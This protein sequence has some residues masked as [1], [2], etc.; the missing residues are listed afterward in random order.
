M[1]WE[2]L[3]QLPGAA[4]TLGLEN[5]GQGGTSTSTCPETEGAA[6]RSLYT[7]WRPLSPARFV[8]DLHSFAQCCPLLPKPLGLWAEYH[9]QSR[10]ARR[11]L[12]LS[13][14]ARQSE[15]CAGLVCVVA[16]GIINF[17][18][19]GVRAEGKSPYPADI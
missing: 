7:A 13:R 12:A 4:A 18:F 11:W 6:V 16:V 14:L 19:L 5:V 1:P 9:S 10:H 3:S 17:R 8:T 2:E 15:A